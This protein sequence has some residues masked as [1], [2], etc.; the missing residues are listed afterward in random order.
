M[1]TSL[2]TFDAMVR[3]TAAAID[4]GELSGEPFEVAHHLWAGIHGYV[5]LEIAGMDLGESDA[6][7]TRTFKQGLARLV[8]GC[9]P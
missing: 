2:G 9:R 1:V 3:A 8:K 6:Q 5:A 4:A 7:R